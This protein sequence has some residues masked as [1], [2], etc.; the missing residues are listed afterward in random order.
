MNRW[1]V[2]LLQ[3]TLTL[4][5]PMVLHQS[6]VI[7]VS[8]D[9]WNI[10][11]HF[12]TFSAGISTMLRNSFQAVCTYGRENFESWGR[13][14]RSI[15]NEIDDA[16]MSLSR[17]GDQPSPS[18]KPFSS[19][20]SL[21]WTSETRKPVRMTLTRPPRQHLQEATVSKHPGFIRLGWARHGLARIDLAWVS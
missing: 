9:I 3:R 8:V 16:T 15:E 5:F 4:N 14:K 21:S 19:G 11:P 6:L 13:K 20:K 2:V 10:L 7:Y 1:V 18:L 12:H 17:Y